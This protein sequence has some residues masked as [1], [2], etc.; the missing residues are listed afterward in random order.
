MGYGLWGEGG[1]DGVGASDFV[2]LLRI[3]M[4]MWMD[5]CGSWKKDAFFRA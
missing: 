3:S 1:E 2:G 4:K 5:F